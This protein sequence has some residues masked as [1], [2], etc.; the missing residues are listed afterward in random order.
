MQAPASPSTPGPAIQTAEGT[1]RPA[2]AARSMAFGEG[3]R[4]PGSPSTA[5]T[6]PPTSTSTTWSADAA[7][8]WAASCRWRS[9]TPPV[10]S[11]RTSVASSG[12]TSAR[13]IAG[14][15]DPAGGIGRVRRVTMRRASPADSR[16]RGGTVRID[17]AADRPCRQSACAVSARRCHRDSVAGSADVQGSCAGSNPRTRWWRA[18]PLSSSVRFFGR[19]ALSVRI[20]S[21]AAKA[22]TTLVVA[23]VA[24]LLT[25]G[26]AYLVGWFND[27]GKE[28]AAEPTGVSRIADAPC[29]AEI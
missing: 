27:R 23:L 28:V 29:T 2:T 9:T 5:R 22:K 10:G 25:G 26:A 1:S 8:A 6:S 19:R 17:P 14:S 4:R 16:S 20:R 7:K 21:T 3:L 11:R 24:S 15:V 18:S 12:P 13:A